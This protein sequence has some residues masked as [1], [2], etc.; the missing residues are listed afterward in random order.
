MSSNLSNLVLNTCAQWEVPVQNV[1]SLHVRRGKY[2]TDSK[3]L[4]HFIQL[5][6]NTCQIPMK[7]FI[8]NFNNEFTNHMTFR[9]LG[10]DFLWPNRILF[11]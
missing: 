4:F 3:S 9:N 5:Y 7:S 6:K 1:M 8:Q 2:G 11:T 10:S